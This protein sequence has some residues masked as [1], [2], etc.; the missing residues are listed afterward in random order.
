MSSA[1][2]K[3]RCNLAG[4]SLLVSGRA[5]GRPL[6]SGWSGRRATDDRS[7][8]SAAG[9]PRRRTAFAD[10]LEGRLHARRLSQRQIAQRSGV[11]HATVSRLLR[12]GRVPS[13]ATVAKLARAIGDADSPEALAAMLGPGVLDDVACRVERALCSDPLLSE[14]QVERLMNLYRLERRRSPGGPVGDSQ[15]SAESRSAAS[16]PHRNRLGPSAHAAETP[17]RAPW[18]SSPTPSLSPD[19]TP[20]PPPASGRLPHR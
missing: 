1:D 10:W 16:S 17:G 13:L 12:D 18:P 3:H 20:P 8:R 4:R 9:R 15:R 5:A 7:E 2:P 11:D 6:V 19:G 14:E